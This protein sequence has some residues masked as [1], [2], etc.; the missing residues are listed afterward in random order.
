MGGLD[1]RIVLRGVA[2]ALAVLAVAWLALWYFIPAPPSTI[3]IA[4]SSAYEHIAR[5]YQDRLAAHHVKLL[6]RMENS[7]AAVIALLRDPNSGLDAGLTLGIADAGEL[8]SFVSL[9]RITHSPIWFFYRGAET[10]GHLSQL[11]GKRVAVGP[12]SRRISDQILA[13]YG[14]RN[15]N[16]TVLTLGAAMRSAEGLRTAEVDVMS[17]AQEI[18]NPYIQSLLH[19]PDIRIMNLAQAEALT[20]LFPSLNRVMLPQGVIDPEKN[21]PANDVNLVALTSVVLARSNLHPETIYLLA[22]TMKEEHSRAGIFNRAGEF[23]TQVDPDFPIAEEAA[24]YYKN[25]ASFLHRYLPFW[26]IN[27][28]KRAIAILLAAFAVVIPLFTYGPKAYHWFLRAHLKTLYRRL[29]AIEAKLESEPN[30]KDIETL[31]ADL[32]S[33]SRAARILPTRHSDLFIDLVMHIRQTRSELLRLMTPR[34]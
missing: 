14:V 9:G 30:A 21:V 13:L 28:A 12:S 3:T 19:D 17:T 18:N 2:A 7:S 6:I 5:R 4:T 33:I 1:A 25:G 20:K 27:Y 11:K 23:P 8:P 29:R 16:T 15:E 24:D 31:Q 32:Q 34:G 26:M 22:Q 10:L